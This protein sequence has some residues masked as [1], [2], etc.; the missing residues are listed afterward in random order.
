M[1]NEL[2]VYRDIEGNNHFIFDQSALYDDSQLGNQLSDFEVLRIL[3]SYNKKNAISKVRSLKNNKIYSMKKIDLTAIK[4]DQEKELFFKQMEK[5]KSLNHSHLLKYYKTFQDTNNNLYLIFDYMDNSDLN[6]L[7][8]AHCNLKKE[9]KE[10]TVWNILLQ[11]LSGISYLHKENLAALAIRPTNI[12]L[13]NEQNTKIG[14][15]YETPKLEDKDYDIR[16][17]I[18]FIGRYF[19]KM[20]FLI[21]T[22]WVFENEFKIEIEKKKEAKYSGELVDIIYKMCEKDPNKRLSSLD[23]YNLVKKEYVSKFCNVTSIEAVLRCLYSYPN[24]NQDMMNI[25]HQIEI[26]QEKY[27]ISYWY[28]K[29]YNAIFQNKN[30]NECFEEFRRAL[31]SSSSKID[32]SKEVDPI[33]LFTFLMEKMQ[34]ELNQ[35]KATVVQNQNTNDQ[36]VINSIYRME[37]KEDKT[38]KIEMWNKFESY[39]ND[40]VRSV[41]STNFYGVRKIKKLCQQCFNGF[42]SYI[43][44]FCAAFD[45]RER[46]N[47]N[48]QFNLENEINK[49]RMVE[50]SKETAHFMCEICLTEQDIKEYDD[51]YKMNQH[52]TICLYRGENYIINTKINFK[53]FMIVYE[54]ESRNAKQ[55]HLNRQVNYKLI[56]AVNR[57]IKNGKEEFYYYCRDINNEGDWIT[58]DGIYQTN[59]ALN[60]IQ[61]NG[62]VI[63][64]FYNKM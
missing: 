48:E 3:G 34:K 20:I 61:D 35:K 56:G 22:H 60:M 29:S 32:C 7:I 27:Y 52:L 15:F 46:E 37:E 45:L 39:F 41:I 47:N 55:M 10:E 21:N 26:N 49:V 58:K 33:R 17:D 63:M 59:S 11:C 36:Y 1:G 4:K 2:E 25:S 19:Y 5:L 53:E 50:K 18:Y 6:S 23:L 42:Y 8:K 14:L 9:V 28:L 44:F 64:L 54:M 62:Q 38:N 30:L 24:F 16:D 40:N 13:D 12:F 31:A 51:Y 43:N 57:I